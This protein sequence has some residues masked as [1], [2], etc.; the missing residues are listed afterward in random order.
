[1]K[2][3][4]KAVAVEGALAA[5]YFAMVKVTGWGMLPAGMTMVVPSPKATVAGRMGLMAWETVITAVP[6]GVGVIVGVMVEVD[7]DVGVRVLVKVEVK[8]DVKVFV[9][10]FVRVK[11]EVGVK[12]R[13]KVGVSVLV[14]V[15]EPGVGVFV[16]VNV[17]VLVGRVPVIVGV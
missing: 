3:T 10:V 5:R 11:V 2:L 9:D 6:A 12:V 14:K 8:V 1:M 17:K 15:G 4:W 7:V 16:T 13:V